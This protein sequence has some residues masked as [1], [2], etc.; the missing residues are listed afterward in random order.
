M[1]TY[2]PHRKCADYAREDPHFQCG[3]QC[4]E[5]IQLVIHTRY[6][7]FGPF[8]LGCGHKHGLFDTARR[9]CPALRA[10]VAGDPAYEVIVVPRAALWY[11]DEYDGLECVREGRVWRDAAGPEAPFWRR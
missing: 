3:P 8:D 11:I 10:A 6:G 4:P 5:M 7:G 1:E 2:D 9:D